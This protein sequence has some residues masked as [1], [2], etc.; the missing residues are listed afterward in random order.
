MPR[1]TSHR[2]PKAMAVTTWAT[3]RRCR[4][5]CVGRLQTPH[6]AGLWTWLACPCCCRACAPSPHPTHPPTHSMV[7]PLPCTR[8]AR[9]DLPAAGGALPPARLC[10]PDLEVRVCSRGGSFGHLLLQG[11]LTLQQGIAGRAAPPQNRWASG[12]ASKS[13][14]ERRR[15]APSRRMRHARSVVAPS[16]WNTFP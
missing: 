5:R 16:R 4:D 12:A 1:R 15:L 7:G 6:L 13:L 11:D 3:A 8:L 9:R 10:R 14:G 2:T